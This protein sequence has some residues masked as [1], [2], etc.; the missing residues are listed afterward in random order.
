M[1]I[2]VDR[3]ATLNG[4]LCT[5]LQT[6]TAAEYET[7]EQFA[8][9]AGRAIARVPIEPALG[10]PA[11]AIVLRS[12]NESSRPLGAYLAFGLALSRLHDRLKNAG[13]SQTVTLWTVVPGQSGDN[14]ARLYPKG[15]GRRGA[16]ER[17]EWLP[18]ESTE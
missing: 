15:R 7:L 14:A 11:G 5:T 10:G 12:K 4:Q 16:R 9:A 6:E 2:E 18:G 13:K 8:A 17:G 1:D 3:T